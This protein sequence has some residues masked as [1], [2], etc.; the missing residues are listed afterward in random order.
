MKEGKSSAVAE[1]PRDA[2]CLSVVSSEVYNTSSV[3]FYYQLLR[4][5]IYDSVLFS[6]AYS[7]TIAVINKIH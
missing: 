1:R 5:Q 2:S 7:S 4:L 3:V 6:A